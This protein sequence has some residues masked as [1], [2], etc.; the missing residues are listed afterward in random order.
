MPNSGVFILMFND[1]IKNNRVPSASQ[2]RK[3]RSLCSL[4]HP[5]I[6]PLY[7]FGIRDNGTKAVTMNACYMFTCNIIMLDTK[8]IRTKY[9]DH[10]LSYKEWIAP[11]HRGTLLDACIPWLDSISSTV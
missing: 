5:Q 10:I 1:H 4:R 3:H 8:D 2:L 11:T 9:H 6:A 7:F